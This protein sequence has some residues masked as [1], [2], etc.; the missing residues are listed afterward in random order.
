MPMTT[1]RLQ[2]TNFF[3]LLLALLMLLVIFPL[4]DDLN[5]AH[6]HL[7]RS[8][9]FSGFLVVAIWSLRGGGLY[10]RIGLSLV[11]VGVLLNILAANTQSEILQ[12][13]SILALVGFLFIAIPFSLRV[14]AIGN[15]ITANRIVGAICIYLLLGMLWALFYTVIEL[16]VPG[17]FSGL[18]PKEYQGWDSDWLYLSFVTM[19]TLG[20]GDVLPVTAVARATAYMQAIIGQF[21]IATLVAGLVGAFIAQQKN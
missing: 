1:R 6:G 5:I 10:F 16:L 19:T 3:Y 7:V 2:K 21:Y 13:C 20:Y 9:L 11:A 14:V 17:S 8:T 18:S 12:L 4:A 15:D